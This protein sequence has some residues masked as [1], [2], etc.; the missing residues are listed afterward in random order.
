M[1]IH[2][3]LSLYIYIYICISIYIELYTYIYIYIIYI[4]IYIYIY[5]SRVVPACVPFFGIFYVE[6]GILAC[7]RIHVLN[8]RCSHAG[9]S[10]K[11]ML[12]SK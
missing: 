7:T 9:E 10:T 6:K 11:H 3:S 12:R 2:L 8:N 5:F 1:Y 4:Y